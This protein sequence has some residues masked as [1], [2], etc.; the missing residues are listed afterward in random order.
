MRLLYVVTYDISDDKRWRR[1]FKL[2]R[3]HGDHLQYSVF[4]CELSDRE[5]VQL[6]EKLAAVIKKDED[7]VLFFPLGP[8]G[9]QR[10]GEVHAVGRPYTATDHS[11]VII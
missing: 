2:M 7:Q 11:P 9:G 5:R 3:G 6:M 1:V 10:E 8:A 4:R